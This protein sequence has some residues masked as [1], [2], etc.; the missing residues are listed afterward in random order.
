MAPKSK[1]NP[2]YLTFVGLLGWFIPG[3]G[4]FMIRENVRGAIVLITIAATFF[5]GIY[6]GSIGV[7]D[8]QS[9][10]PWYIAQIMNSPLVQIIANETAGGRYPVY[11]KPNE[12][13]QIYTGI[14]GLL[15]LLCVINAVYMAHVK[16][17]KPTGA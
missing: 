12:L 8:P 10:W 14:A 13:G 7:I 15:N 9:C 4:Y 17:V 16:S 3:G 11:G 5:T 2:V 6:I 1:S